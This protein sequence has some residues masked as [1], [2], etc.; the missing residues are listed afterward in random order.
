MNELT[1]N[2]ILS[3]INQCLI[4]IN[5]K[6]F[7]VGGAVRS[8]L[9]EKKIK[10]IDIIVSG[11][12]KKFSEYFAKTH[13]GKIIELDN[14][15]GIYRVI[16]KTNL[17]S[18]AIDISPINKHI[19][20]DL[21]NRDFTI[22][23]IA[24][25][26]IKGYKNLAAQNFIDPSNGIKDLNQKILRS[27]NEKIFE[28]D[29][30]RLLRAVRIST[31]LGFEISN[32]TY[33]Q[34]QKNSHLIKFIAAERIKDEFLKILSLQNSMNGVKLLDELYLLS[35]IIP[36]IDEAKKITQPKEH[37]WDVFNHLIETIG[38]LE[39]ILDN[40]NANK[41]ID[42]YIP[43]IKNEKEYFNEIIFEGHTRKTI[44]KLVALI[45]DISK[46]E[47]KT[48]EKSGK[49]RFLGHDKIGAKKSIKIL[50]KLK[51]SNKSIEFITSIIANHL[52]PT[53]MSQKHELPSNRALNRYLRDLQGIAIDTLYLNLADYLSARGELLQE[54][55]WAEHCKLINHILNHLKAEKEEKILP[56]LV[57]GYDIMNVLSIKS[58]PKIG[59]ILKKIEEAQIN[60]YIKTREEALNI[61]KNQNS[62][63]DMIAKTL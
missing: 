15:R 4:K 6:G 12:S 52:R 17:F 22:D 57:S 27:N 58:G 31:E 24:I 41:F 10:D 62:L 56:K 19:N 23:S 1:T 13:D 47:T 11:S 51:M 54:K 38:A 33:K 59:V 30:I 9:L 16:F 3:R 36:E 61:I 25:D 7:L 26:L 43:R 42:R 44:L 50:R 63:G 14:V 37:Y 2:K 60:E 5:E 55:E 21:K 29:P 46:P 32:D 40:N 49:I 39:K 53:Q 48:V 20:N 35:K 34:I 28:N 45:H 18:H 8:I